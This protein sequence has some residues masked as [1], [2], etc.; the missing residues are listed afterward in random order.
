MTFRLLFPVI[1]TTLLA[2]LPLSASAEAEPDQSGTNSEIVENSTEDKT[3]TRPEDI[4][5]CLLNRLK[6]GRDET[7]AEIREHCD[8]TGE[9]LPKA[10]AIS[11]RFFDERRTEFNPFVIT[12]HRMNY[13]LPVSYTTSINREAYAFS[14]DWTKDLKDT[15]A[16][17]QISFKV[18]LNYNSM[19]M[20]GD[21]LYFGFTLQSWWQVY[22]NEIS[23]PFRE[24]NY[25]PE[26]FYTT[27]LAWKIAGGNTGFVLGIEHQSNGRSQALSR[28]WNRVYAA[29]MYERDHF[30]MAIRPWWRLPEDKKTQPG[31]SDGDDNPDIDDYMGHFELTMAHRW[32]DYVLNFTG[33]QN[34]STG[35]GYA[36][37]GLTFPLWG[38]LRGYVQYANGY[39][40][41][42]IDYN[43][44]QQR[45]GV[46][47]ALTDLL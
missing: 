4:D 20:D 30:A 5:Q 10:G 15:E 44:H 40:E 35:N 42:L 28:S 6:L 23:A 1:T 33:R 24:T 32:D 29:M 27:P 22:A 9:E 21:G 7:V 47:I 3:G 8:P 12:P 31:E 45:I 16:K 2:F 34:F 37:L 17:F 36:E 43:H 18:P 46:G 26:V 39:G 19:F 11:H 38:R 25:Q 13:I 14:N 41:S